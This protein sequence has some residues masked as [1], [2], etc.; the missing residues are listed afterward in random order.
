MSKLAKIFTAI[1]PAFFSNGK[2]WVEGGEVTEDGFTF[3]VKEQSKESILEDYNKGY[4]NTMMMTISMTMKPALIKLLDQFP[5]FRAY[6]KTGFDDIGEKSQKE[7]T[8]YYESVSLNLKK[9]MK[10]S[11]GGFVRNATKQ[12][13]IVDEAIVD[14]RKMFAEKEQELKNLMMAKVNKRIQYIVEENNESFKQSVVSALTSR[15]TLNELLEGNK[16]QDEVDALKQ[17][18]D[19][20]T[21]KI[22]AEIKVYKEKIA[23]LQ[24][25]K[26]EVYK[27]TRDEFFE[28]QLKELPPEVQEEVDSKDAYP[29]PSRFFG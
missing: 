14:L 19:I 21:G 28:K 15:S 1:F 12:S 2:E 18:H 8:F 16:K 4:G 20:E 22:E 9:R 13:H 11:K 26:S 7:F 27:A 25:K 29:Q 24:A 5:Y 3:E 10:T 23:E 17:K 6:G